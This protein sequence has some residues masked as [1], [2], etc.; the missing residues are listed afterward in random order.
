MIVAK[1]ATR[2]RQKGRR[3]Q[4]TNGRKWT[5]TDKQRTSTDG[6]RKKETRKSECR[7][8]RGK[9]NLSGATVTNSE[10]IGEN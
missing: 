6:A 4:R 5:Y 1:P 10:S 9:E 8:I 7:T 3:A 2:K